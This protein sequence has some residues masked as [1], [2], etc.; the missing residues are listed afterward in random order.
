[1]T[2]LPTT[3]GKYYLTEKLATGGM[4][5][6]YLAKLI[7][8]GGFEKQLV[9]K[10]IHPKL[11]GQR[12]FVDLFVTE[13]KTLVTL[14]HG[15]I[16]PVYELGV[17]DDTYFIAMDYIDGPTLYR[18][19]ET[20]AGR[21]ARMEPAMAAWISARILEGL[22]Y[23]H[24]KGEGVIH[25]D[26]SPR[27]V[28]LSRDGEVKLVDFG[29]AVTLGD[30]GEDAETQS[31]PTGSFPYM[32]PEQVRRE[33][34]TGQT[35]LFSVG[36]LFW[37]ML[38][39]QRLFARPEADATLDA[40]LRETIPPPSSRNPDVP[41]KLDEV[42]MRAL[43]RDQGTRWK[44]A[45][46]MLAALNRYL[47]NLDATPTPRDVAA[48]VAQ[49]CPPQTRRLPTH[50][51]A[52]VQEGALEA[53]RSGPATMPAPAPD[54]IEPPPPAGPRTA[55]IPRDGTEA[56]GK[57]SHQRQKTFATHVE[58]K[59]MLE[60]AT[61][62]FGVEAIGDATPANDDQ[63]VPIVVASAKP[64]APDATEPDVEPVPRPGIIAPK[65]SLPGATSP[66]RALL[67][68]SGIG[69]IALAAVAI[70]MF[71]SGRDRVLRDDAGVPA[72]HD[73]AVTA[74]TSPDGP[75]EPAD[76]P[77]EP[78][79]APA[80]P[81]DAPPLAPRDGGGRRDGSLVRPMTDGSIVALP[82]APARPKGTATLRIGANPWAHVYIDNKLMTD[83]APNVYTVSAGHHAIEL[84][85][86]PPD[87]LKRTKTYDV[88]LGTDETKPLDFDFTH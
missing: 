51:E 4:A 75:P 9:I 27:N 57:R 73:T 59:N 15:N 5:E 78:V 13:A 53:D 40:V 72:V 87:T 64:V 60:R 43:E 76:A 32:S 39:G 49:F 45:G 34:L 70:Y 41:A 46:E 24:R 68:A 28:M 25:R 17:V 86:D 65:F 8:P 50:L 81:V 63:P 29:V 55:V 21:D 31:A 61:P 79:D 18:L 82:D 66:S 74:L 83:L 42:V 80:Q 3:F 23:A 44:D 71:Y 12:H 36:V 54:G 77:A 38:V 35:D 58:L 22:D 37:E 26:L 56:K 7:G 67:V 2:E 11:S 88:D 52:L 1:M 30:A 6:I 10:Q 14:A 33:P 85:F 19:T 84:V 20:M 47:Y 69:A 62:M 48:L 16:V